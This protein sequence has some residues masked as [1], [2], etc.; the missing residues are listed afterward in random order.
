M[1]TLMR[2]KAMPGEDPSDLPRP[3]EMAYKIVEMLS[4]AYDRNETVIN[5]TK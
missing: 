3:E 4:P 1:R 5:F 2:A